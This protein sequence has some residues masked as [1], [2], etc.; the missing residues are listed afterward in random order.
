MIIIRADLNVCPYLLD[1]YLEFADL[2]YSVRKL[3]YIHQIFEDLKVMGAMTGVLYLCEFNQFYPF[4][5][6][7]HLHKYR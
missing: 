3:D 2:F 4:M 1:I 5:L 6:N 7:S